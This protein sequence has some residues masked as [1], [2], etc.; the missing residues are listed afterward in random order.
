MKMVISVVLA[1]TAFCSSASACEGGVGDWSRSFLA[2]RSVRGHFD[3]GTW[4]ASV[5]QWN[6]AKHQAM[7]CLAQHAAAQAAEPTQL[8]QWMGQPD[9]RLRCPSVECNAFLPT[10]QVPAEVWVYRWRANH[11]RLGFAVISGRVNRAQWSY[12]GE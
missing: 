10:L 12:V 1:A 6:G 3:G 11:D 5:D 8:L 7:Q 4:K 2:M 9:E